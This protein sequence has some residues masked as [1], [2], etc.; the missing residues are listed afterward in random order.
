[1]G[2]KKNTWTV[3]DETIPK[4][5]QP[6]SF[7]T[8]AK[9][10]HIEEGIESSI[11]DLQI[12]EVSEGIEADCQIYTDPEDAT[13]KRLNIVIPKKVSW[14]FSTKELHDKETA[15]IKTFPGD[16]ILDIRGNIFSVILNDIGEYRLDKKMNIK[17]DTGPS[18][19][20]GPQGL[21][22]ID[23]SNGNDGK[24]A[25]R[26]IYV[27]KAIVQGEG[28]PDNA[29][30]GDFILDNKGDVFEVLQDMTLNKLIS[31]K[32]ED[33]KTTVND[34]HLEI[35]EVNTGDTAS[36]EIVDG[37][38]LN[39]TIPKGDTGATGLPGIDGK[40]GEKGEQGEKGDPGNAGKDGVSI[41]NVTSNLESD[42]KTIVFTF[43]FSDGNNKTTA[44]TLP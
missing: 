17:G 42:G 19:P 6:N 30:I 43:Y 5:Q 18:G 7:I 4:N 21:P 27:D 39:L 37:N 36:A 22:G 32:G 11:T 10:D 34:F 25:N 41:T 15:P 13:I 12:G 3:Y 23:G 28:S 9:L 33:G 44:V 14:I 24:D 8:K 35:G 16:M 29:N 40:D 2:Y 1:M 31:I 20:A 38:K 26:W